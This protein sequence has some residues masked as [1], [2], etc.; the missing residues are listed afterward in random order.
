MKKPLK[1]HWYKQTLDF[2]PACGRE[3]L[4]KI[5]VYGHKPKVTVTV[6]EVYDHCIEYGRT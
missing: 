5:R 2:C 3:S 1:K 6:N 4:Y